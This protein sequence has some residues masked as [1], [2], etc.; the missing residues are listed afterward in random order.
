[1]ALSSSLQPRRNGFTADPEQGLVEPLP[2]FRTLCQGRFELRTYKYRDPHLHP[3]PHNVVLMIPCD[4]V[5]IRPL[6]CLLV[7][8]GHFWPG[9]N[10]FDHGEIDA[11][12]GNSSL[13]HFVWLLPLPN[14]GSRSALNGET[15][16]DYGAVRR[17]L[18]NLISHSSELCGRVDAAR[19]SLWGISCGGLAVWEAALQDGPY[20]HGLV[21]MAAN[22]PTH[23]LRKDFLSSTALASLGSA[24]VVS[25]HV[26]GAWETKGLHRL[27]AHWQAGQAA[28]RTNRTLHTTQPHQQ[29]QVQVAMH[30]YAV[31]TADGRR[32]AARL[33]VHML[34]GPPLPWWQAD[35][36]MSDE[37]D[38][39]CVWRS[40]LYDAGWDIPGIFREHCLAHAQAPAFW[41]HHNLGDVSCF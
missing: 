23:R 30:S 19:V 5:P 32:N 2:T 39:H 35:G 36:T 37:L 14:P 34:E 38:F 10:K 31:N 13:R 3:D 17:M 6:A 20:Y 12:A 25:L 4:D 27:W 18:A 29:G 40:A 33:N 9:G 7:G 1:M 41:Q 24:M 11:I 15:E 22:V 21:P 8:V 26:D 28:K 16:W